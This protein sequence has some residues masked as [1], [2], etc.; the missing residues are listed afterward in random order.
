ML[1]QS[2]REIDDGR[3]KDIVN[4]MNVHEICGDCDHFNLSLKDQGKGYRCKCM[5]S[6]IADTLSDKLISYM[7]WKLGWI[8]EKD[9]LKNIGI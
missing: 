4:A 1:K 7:N 6:C 8:D 9:H 3:F 2:L 5:P